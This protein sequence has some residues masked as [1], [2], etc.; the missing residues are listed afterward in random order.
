MQSDGTVLDY[1]APRMRS[2]LGG[3]LRW[4][5]GMT[6]ASL[7]CVVIASTLHARI[8]LTTSID[9]GRSQAWAALSVSKWVLLVAVLLCLGARRRSWARLIARTLLIVAAMSW[10]YVNHVVRGSWDWWRW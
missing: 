1:A 5:L 9:G 7:A 2:R 3:R 6:A 10:L 8:V 4:L